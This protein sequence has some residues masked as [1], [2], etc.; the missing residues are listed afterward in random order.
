M[1]TNPDGAAA[2]P[3][4]AEIARLLLDCG[5]VRFGDFT[6]ASGARSDVYVD[7][8]RAWT[9][10]RR[11]ERLARALAA[12]AG[13]E[14]RLA[15][16]EL[17]AVPLVVALALA[18]GRPYAVLRKSAK[19]HGTRQP[20]EGELPVNGRVLLVEDVTTTGG[21][22]VRSVEIVRAAG[23]RVDRALV[24]VDREEGAADRLAA[25]GVRLEPLVRFSEIRAA[26][27]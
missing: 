9:D 12:H 8:K 18:T 25:V 26:R 13:T 15:G 22:T 11:L 10:P 4:S 24:V 6:L 19:E 23:A 20:F 7:V 3:T 27:P 2:P 5:A 17:G 16:M 21:S 1:V 14:E